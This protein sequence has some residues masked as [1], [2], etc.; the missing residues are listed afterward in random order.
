VVSE[1]LRLVLEHGRGVGDCSGDDV[2]SGS[3][4]HPVCGDR[5]QLSLRLAGGVITELRWRAAGC[6]ASMAVAALAA[7]ELAGV[8]PDAA[9]A[10]LRAA[11]AAHGGLGA[12]ER[13]AEGMVL[14]ALAQACGSA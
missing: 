4:E 9:P 2:R 1:R 7:Q 10:A 13:H 8:A 14:R 12:H 11:I 5:V 3:A 6:P